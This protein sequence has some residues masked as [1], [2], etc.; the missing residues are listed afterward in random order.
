MEPLRSASHSFLKYM[1]AID[2]CSDERFDFEHDRRALPTSCS[3]V[4]VPKIKVAASLFGQHRAGASLAGDAT[5]PF[6][7]KFFDFLG[8][9]SVRRAPVYSDLGT[10]SRVTRW[11]HSALVISRRGH[12]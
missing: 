7:W 4:A 2:K 11:G 6:I 5:R 1:S 9:D 12:Q 8:T 3:M 10:E